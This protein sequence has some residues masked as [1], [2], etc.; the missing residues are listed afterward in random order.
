MRIERLRAEALAEL[1]Q[2]LLD[3]WGELL[4]LGAALTVL[5]D[6]VRIHELPI[7]RT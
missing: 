1:V 2:S 4:E 6:R 5:P 7:T 3:R